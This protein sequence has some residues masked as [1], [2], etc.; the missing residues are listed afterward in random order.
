MRI[1]HIKISSKYLK[2]MLQ[3]TTLNYAGHQYDECHLA[4]YRYYPYSYFRVFSR[5]CHSELSTL[6]IYQALRAM[7]PS[8]NHTLRTHRCIK[9]NRWEKLKTEKYE[10]SG[11]SVADHCSITFLCNILQIWCRNWA[12]QGWRFSLLDTVTASVLDPDSD[13]ACPKAAKNINSS[14]CGLM[15]SSGALIGYAGS[16]ATYTRRF[17]VRAICRR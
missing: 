3:D 14:A 15:R 10:P 1:S 17:G 4:L 2:L 8:V 7:R 16:K 12:L 5:W 13:K 6:H 11:K 9:L